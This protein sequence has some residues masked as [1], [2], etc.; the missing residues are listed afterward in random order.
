MVEAGASPLDS[1]NVLLERDQ[2]QY[3]IFNI[4]DI[5]H[6]PRKGI[7]FYINTSIA[8]AFKTYARFHPQ[9]NLADCLERALLKYMQETPLE[10]VSINIELVENIKNKALGSRIE[11]KILVSEITRVL[12]VLD[13]I[14]K[15][16][17]SNY[18]RFLY[19]LQG[20]LMKA[21]KIKTPSESTVKLLERAETYL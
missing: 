19:E 14:K 13:S 15:N 6:G 10:G 16:G 2:K 20:L 8:K 11:E 17:R 7:C 18:P 9:H 1:P 4:S 21:I 12:K 3:Y 5:S